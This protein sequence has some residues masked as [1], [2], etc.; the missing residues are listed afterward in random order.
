[1]NNTNRIPIGRLSLVSKERMCSVGQSSY[2][3]LNGGLESLEL[4]CWI[5]MVEV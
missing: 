3:E 4:V 2:W 5:A 1:M